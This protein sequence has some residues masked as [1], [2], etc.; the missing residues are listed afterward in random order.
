M[1]TYTW[2]AA[3]GQIYAKAAELYAGGARDLDS[4]FDAR[5]RAFLASIG[6]TAQEVFDFVE[7]GVDDGEPDFATV[8]LIAAARRDYFLYVQHGKPSGKRRPL[9]DFPPKGDKLAGIEWLP[10]IIEKARAKLRGEMPAELMYGC[11][12]DRPFLKK[13]DIP[14]A[15]FLRFVWSAGEETAKIV[16]FV[17]ERREAAQ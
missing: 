11:G 8:L 10:R 15:D 5:D 6:H 16:E 9:D 17:K 13:Y 7:D 4:L 3:F 12:G 1:G 14:P 2:A